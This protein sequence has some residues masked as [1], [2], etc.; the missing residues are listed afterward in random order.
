MLLSLDI[1]G[2]KIKAKVRYRD[3]LVNC[4]HVWVDFVSDKILR[5]GEAN[6]RIADEIS[7]SRHS[8]PGEEGR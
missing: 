4:E 5:F 7:D 1:G 2:T 8:H 3:T 6:L